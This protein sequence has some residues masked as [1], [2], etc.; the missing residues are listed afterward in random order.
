MI[1]AIDWKALAARYKWWVLLALIVIVGIV[2]GVHA[3][4]HALFEALRTALGTLK[5]A[6]E[7]APVQMIVIYFLIYV[8]TAA[9]SLPFGG[10]LTLAAGALFGFWWGMLLALVSAST[11]ALAGFVVSRYL[12]H[13]R[14]Q[15]RFGERLA[16]I[17]K[18]LREEGAFYL[19]SLRM[20]P[21]FPYWLANLLM[22]LTT[23]PAFTFWWVSVL[24]L[25][26]IEAAYVFAG[27]QVA[28]VAD[29]HGRVLSLKLVAA[30]LGLAVLPLLLRRVVRMIERKYFRHAE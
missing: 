29:S 14:V 16:P 7:L 6:V 21:V 18:G 30:L 26:P 27:T 22:G 9:I 28:D 25:V 8:A 23:M 15:R 24:G 20:V 1:G 2:S 11:G 3:A 12:F 5:A 4:E 19:F 17:N 10:I 13:D